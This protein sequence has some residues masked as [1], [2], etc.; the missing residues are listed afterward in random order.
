[1]KSNPE[2]AAYILCGGKSSRMGQEK[3]LVIWKGNSFLGWILEALVPITD[4]MCLVTNCDAYQQYNLP[5]IPDL[6]EDKGPVGGIY[7]ALHHSKSEWNLILS[8]DIPK[9]KS[10]LLLE[11]IEHIKSDENLVVIASDGIYDY[12]LIGIYHQS[13]E[14][15]FHQAIQ[16][17]KLKLR[18]LVDSLSP[19]KLLINPENQKYLANVNSL[20]ELEKQT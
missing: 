7:S 4:K 2:I 12:P 16:E 1:M 14:Y 20:K 8:C 17:N 5:L 10:E 6:V 11:L 15:E 18:D 13:L 9:I 19:K 3:G